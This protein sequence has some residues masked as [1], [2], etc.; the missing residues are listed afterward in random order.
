[1]RGNDGDECW[2]VQELKEAKE[3]K[4]SNYQQEIILLKQFKY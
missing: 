3:E 1:M 2:H 4:N